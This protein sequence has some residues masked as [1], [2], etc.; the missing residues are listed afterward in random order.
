MLLQFCQHFLRSAT[1]PPVVILVRVAWHQSATPDHNGFLAH[2]SAAAWGG[3]KV[4]VTSFWRCHW[5][6]EWGR[7]SPSPKVKCSADLWSRPHSRVQSPPRALLQWFSVNVVSSN[8]QLINTNTWFSVIVVS[9]NYQ[10]IKNN[11]LKSQWRRVRVLAL[12]SRSLL[13]T[14]EC[15]QQIDGSLLRARLWARPEIS[16]ESNSVQSLQKSLGWNYKPKSH[17]CIHTHANRSHTH[18]KYPVVQVR[19]RWIMGTPK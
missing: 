7:R 18:V 16:P 2:T 3:V 14:I 11:A 17:L 6:W 15:G 12:E 9:S 13:S 19:V 1:S 5:S 10:L 8:Y 4:T